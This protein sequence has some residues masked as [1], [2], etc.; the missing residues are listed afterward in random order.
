MRT[1]QFN[2]EIKKR[3]MAKIKSKLYRKIK[4]RQKLREEA[5][6]VGELQ[7]EE[8]RD[9]IEKLAKQRMKERITLRHRSKSQHIQNLLRFSKSN[10][11][12]IQ[13]T[14]N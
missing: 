11:Q 6:R 5:K 2:E 13:D 8:R 4:K 10:K 7:G 9:Y 12:G 3:R 1:A 14:L